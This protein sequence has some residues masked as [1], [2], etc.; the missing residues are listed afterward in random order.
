[1]LPCIHYRLGLGSISLTR[2][3][4]YVHAVVSLPRKDLRTISENTTS[5]M[6]AE[7]EEFNTLPLQI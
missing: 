1:L 6:A 4:R 3:R 5:F 7:F 2:T